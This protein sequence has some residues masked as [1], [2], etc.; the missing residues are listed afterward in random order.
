MGA[1]LPARWPGGSELP[2]ECQI[3][4][5]IDWKVLWPVRCS[6][7]LGGVLRADQFSFEQSDHRL[8]T[9]EKKPTGQPLT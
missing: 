6:A 7:W 9:L 8:A 2:V 5:S 3:V 4:P 1:Q